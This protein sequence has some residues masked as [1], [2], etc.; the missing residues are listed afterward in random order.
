MK[1]SLAWVALCMLLVAGGCARK[2]TVVVTSQ[3]EKVEMTQSGNQMT[4]E[5]KEGKME[6]GK[7]SVG[8]KELGVTVYPGA[9]QS[10]GMTVTGTTE[11]KGNF[12]TAAFTTK[13]S[14]DKVLAYYKQQV[15]PS[16]EFTSVNV[17]GAQMAMMKFNKG[18]MIVQ[19]QL[20]SDAKKGETLISIMSGKKEGKD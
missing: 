19:V 17:P 13:D 2:K 3:G 10:G 20:T 9:T 11:E 5:S 4:I 14:F 7:V 16:A 12:T 6:I 8:E 18:G 1:K 15:P